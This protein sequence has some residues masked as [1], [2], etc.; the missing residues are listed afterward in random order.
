[1]GNLHQVVMDNNKNL[2]K[3]KNIITNKK[4]LDV[5]PSKKKSV[6]LITN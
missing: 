6:F 4:L 1:M 3:I 2:K 5:I